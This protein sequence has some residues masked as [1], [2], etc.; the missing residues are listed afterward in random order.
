MQ[1]VKGQKQN[2]ALKQFILIDNINSNSVQ[3][4]AYLIAQFLKK[5]YNNFNSS[6]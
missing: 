1:Q 3:F 5:F 4:N 6:L 2:G